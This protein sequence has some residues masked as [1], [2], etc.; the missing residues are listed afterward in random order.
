[1][2]ILVFYE[3][4]CIWEEI[5]QVSKQTAVKLRTQ[6]TPVDIFMSYIEMPGKIVR[7]SNFRHSTGRAIPKYLD[8]WNRKRGR[9][10][11]VP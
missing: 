2:F 5:L 1:M 11:F 4:L 10:P 3:F 6:I 7:M 8:K 9:C